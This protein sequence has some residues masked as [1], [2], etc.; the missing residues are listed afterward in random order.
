MDI[1]P[2]IAMGCQLGQSLSARL[3]ILTC[4]RVLKIDDLDDVQHDPRA[5][6]P[7]EGRGVQA[8]IPAHSQAPPGMPHHSMKIQQA[9]RSQRSSC[10]LPVLNN[11]WTYELFTI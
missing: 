5:A 8:P 9:Q 11:E 4:E 1:T 3:L 6:K 2:N 10:S 7:E